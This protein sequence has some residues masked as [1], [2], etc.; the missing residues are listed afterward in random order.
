MSWDL[1]IVGCGC[2]HRTMQRQVGRSLLTSNLQVWSLGITALFL[3]TNFSPG[4][5][6]PV[7][8][9]HI[10]SNFNPVLDIVYIVQCMD[11]YCP[12]QSTGLRSGRQLI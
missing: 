7:Q 5:E 12:F 8:L 11:S 2:G 3:V 6:P 1:V 9:L 4:L 10:P